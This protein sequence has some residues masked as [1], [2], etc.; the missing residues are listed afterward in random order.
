MELIIEDAEFVTMA[1]AS[2]PADAMLVR[3]GRIAAVGPAEAVRA[4]ASPRAGLARLGGATVIPGLITDPERI[5]DIRVLATVL[6]G[7]PVYQ[8]ESIF[9]G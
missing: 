6:G 1:A 2:G 4:A 3:D 9:A 7:T 5:T 8:S